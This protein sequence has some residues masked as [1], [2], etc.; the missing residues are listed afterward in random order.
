MIKVNQK[1]LELVQKEFIK[2]KSKYSMSTAYIETEKLKKVRVNTS[3]KIIELGNLIL[4]K[5]LWLTD[6]YSINLA[7]ER[8]DLNGVPIKDHPFLL[9][10]IQKLWDQ[11]E[12]KI[13]L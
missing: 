1:A 7:D 3:K 12:M 13:S 2:Q 6:K 11:V 9:A 10:R 5:D 8:K 4:K